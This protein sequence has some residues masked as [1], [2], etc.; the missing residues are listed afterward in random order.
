MEFGYEEST[1]LGPTITIVD[2]NESLKHNCSYNYE[3]LVP[4]TK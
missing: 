3:V 4:Y 2:H 1:S